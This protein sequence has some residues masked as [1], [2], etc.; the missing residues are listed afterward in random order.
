MPLEPEENENSHPLSPLAALLPTAEGEDRQPTE[1]KVDLSTV[2]ILL[3][4]YNRGGR[5]RPLA[6]NIYMLMATGKHDALIIEG[7]ISQA[8]SDTIRAICSR[9]A[10]IWESRIERGDKPTVTFV[11]DLM[12][13]GV[14]F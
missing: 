8:E 5:S 4:D 10:Q 11:N 9:A 2:T 12:K 13:Q 1:I 6:F 7:I 14:V 3:G